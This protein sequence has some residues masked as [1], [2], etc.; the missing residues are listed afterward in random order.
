[1]EREGRKVAEKMYSLKINKYSL[2][3]PQNIELNSSMCGSSVFPGLHSVSV[4]CCWVCLG[5]GW[6]LAASCWPPL[7][8]FLSSSSDFSVSADQPKYIHMH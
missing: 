4:V 2:S 7:G 5:T 3:C 1:M 8:H 6:G